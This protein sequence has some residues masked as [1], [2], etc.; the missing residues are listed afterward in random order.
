MINVW[1]QGIIGCDDALAHM[2]QIC[3]SEEEIS[4][5]I[6]G[7]KPLLSKLNERQCRYDLK[8]SSLFIAKMYLTSVFNTNVYASHFAIEATIMSHSLDC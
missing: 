3:L 1:C 7:D 2:G 4:S 5:L 6:K 8:N